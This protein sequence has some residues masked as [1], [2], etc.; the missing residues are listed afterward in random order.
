MK[1]SGKARLKITVDGLRNIAL[2][3]AFMIAN[4]ARHWLYCSAIIN[5]Y[6]NRVK[7]TRVSAISKKRPA[8][9]FGR[10]AGTLAMIPVEN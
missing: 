5:I 10:R 7:L 8:R 2:M 3:L 6:K 9:P 1:I 4:M